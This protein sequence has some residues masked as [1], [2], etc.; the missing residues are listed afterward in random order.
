MPRGYAD[1]WQDDRWADVD[2]VLVAEEA[3]NPAAQQ[4][5]QLAKFPGHR[6]LL[7]S[8]PYLSAQLGNP[9]RYR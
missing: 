7:S 1:F 6:L 2:I 5:I 9:Q 4:P 8:S 3:A